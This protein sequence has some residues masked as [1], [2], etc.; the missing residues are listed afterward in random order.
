[1]C[2]GERERLLSS[3]FIFF[4]EFSI[5][6]YTIYLSLRIVIFVF[7]K[8]GIRNRTPPSLYFR[9]NPYV[10]NECTGI[11][12]ETEWSVLSLMVKATPSPSEWSVRC[13][14]GA[15]HWVC[16]SNMGFHSRDLILVT[17]R[18]HILPQVFC[19]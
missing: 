16:V 18:S 14:S 19:E 12:E 7:S 1:M 4:E 2:Q 10:E 6:L 13:P 8:L 17:P 9:V 3:A 15:C 5:P 11:L